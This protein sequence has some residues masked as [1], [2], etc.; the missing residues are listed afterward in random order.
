MTPADLRSLAAPLYGNHGWQSRL[1]RE[2][3]VA[4][5]TVQRWASGVTPIHADTARRLRAFLEERA[6]QKVNPPPAD[7]Y[8]SRDDDAYDEMRP[9]IQALVAAA[10]VA[11][12]HQ[13]ETLTAILAVTVDEIRGA[14]IPVSIEVLRQV[15][16]SLK[17]QRD[18]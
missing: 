9:R 5:R 7:G 10:T 12:W 6:R 4:I 17:A 2:W 1:A 16:D 13:A 8:T 18:T 11:G 14:G 15:T 3:G